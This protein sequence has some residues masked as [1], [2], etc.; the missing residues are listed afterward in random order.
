M[1]IFTICDFSQFSKRISELIQVQAGEAHLA[2]ISFH[3]FCMRLKTFLVKVSLFNS[4]LGGNE[5]CRDHLPRARE[6]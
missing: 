5:G 3:L 6:L 2:R 1:F 4:F